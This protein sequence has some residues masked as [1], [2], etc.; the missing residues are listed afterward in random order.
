MTRMSRMGR[1]GLWRRLVGNRPIV[2]RL[3]LAV[4]S[5]MAVVLLLA[6]AFV[7][8]RVQYAL[9]RQLDQD[10]EAYREVVERAV[11]TDQTP[12]TD[13]PGQ[14]YQV[15][16]RDGSVTAGNAKGRLIGRDAVSRAEAGTSVRKDVGSFLPPAATP[17]RVVARQVRTPAGPVVVATAISKHKHDEALRELLLQLTLADLVT[18]AAASLAGYA[19]ARAALNPVERYRIAAEQ[20]EEP[21]LLPVRAGRND[22]VARLG[23]TLNAMLERIRRTNER[24]R[25]FLADAAHELR[26]PL[27]LMSTELEFA[28]MKPRDEAETR[29]ALESLQGQVERLI[30]LANALLDIEELR[31]STVQREHVDLDE[32]V[33][34][35]TARFTQQAAAVGRRVGVRLP[36]GHAVNGNRHWLEL[37]L[38]NLVSNAL[39][40]GEGTVL[41]TA[42]ETGS[43]TEISVEDEGPGFP[44]DFIDKA[45]DRF[46]RADASRSTRGPGGTGLGLALVQAVAQAHGGTTTISGSRVTLTLPNTPVR[47]RA[48]SA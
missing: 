39:R 29:A 4:A 8:W 21:A 20:G 34:T 28:L 19:T 14:S 44:E 48:G 35:V 9:D 40:Y 32:L 1:K 45:F 18:L 37:A 42:R 6:G 23:H 24:E 11:S 25:Q 13:T 33:D 3:V 36:P 22:E 47:S 10:L 43:H 41:V 38:G 5:T 26:S 12:P 16:G 30:R 7:F 27:A 2:T 17:Y 31:A 15:Y 46:S